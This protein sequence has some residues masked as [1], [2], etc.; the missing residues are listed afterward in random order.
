MAGTT[1]VEEETAWGH[2]KGMIEFARQHRRSGALIDSKDHRGKRQG[3]APHWVAE[4]R[5]H[6]RR[7]PTSHLD[8]LTKSL[9]CSPVAA[10]IPLL[11][12][13]SYFSAYAA[14]P[15]ARGHRSSGSVSQNHRAQLAN[16]YNEL[17]KE[18]SSSK[19]RVVGNYTLSKV[20]GEGKSAYI[21]LLPASNYLAS[22]R[23]LWQ[24]PHGDPSPH[25]HSSSHQANPES[26]VGHPHTRNPS[27]PP[28]PSSPYCPDV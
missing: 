11:S 27:S 28:A 6:K 10:P 24:S 12:F 9:C 3:S 18:L 4:Y 15:S 21:R 16:A 23:H 19:I 14:M 2:G 17:G 7:F 25:L 22:P 26:H 20:I 8:L 1:K 5:Q 13:L